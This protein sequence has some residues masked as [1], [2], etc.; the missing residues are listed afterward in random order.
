[1]LILEIAYLRDAVVAATP[2]NRRVPEWPPHPDRLLSALVATWSEHGS[3][4]AGRAALEW[5]EGLGPPTIHA[6]HA[7]RRDVADHYVPPNDMTVSGKP[8]SGLPRDASTSLAVLPALRTNRQPRQFPAVIPDD[9]RVRYV[10]SEA[11]SDSTHLPALEA[12]VADLV[13]LG[14]S[15]ALVRAAVLPTEIDPSDGDVLPAWTPTTD[16]SAT[17]H[18]IRMAYPGRV[19]ELEAGYAKGSAV[20][21]PF[22]PTPGP[23]QAYRGPDSP[24]TRR[25]PAS[26]FGDS[27]IVLSD[28]GGDA[29]PALNAVPA[30]AG[31]L[32]DAIIAAAPE[33]VPEVLSGHTPDGAPSRDPHL[34]IVPLADVGRRYAGGRLMGLGLALPRKHAERGDPARSSLMRALANLAQRGEDGEIALKLGPMGVWRLGHEPVPTKASLKPQIYADTARVWASVTPVL[35][36]RHPKNKPGQRIGDLV[37]AAC[38]NIGL[39][40]PLG[41]ELHRHAPVRQGPS[42][43]TI[44]LPKGSALANRPL[45]HVVLYFAE[46]VTGPVLLGA[47]RFR[48]LGLCRL[49]AE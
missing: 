30:V 1:M 25:A 14:H 37:A 43:D 15:Q 35:L 36:D 38:E 12:L 26:V 44:R 2:W 39:P 4:P 10:W 19:A 6:A 11:A 34:A 16:V 31:R 18:Q 13:Y 5:M 20:Q 49:V 24:E 46:P 8:G 7:Q 17:T 22:R 40:A 27:W 9:P 47:G 42:C 33:P 48:G 32:R 41:V 28:A 29:T 23:P 21:P 45:R 3:D